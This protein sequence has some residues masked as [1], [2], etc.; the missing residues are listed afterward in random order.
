M[1]NKDYI[2]QEL[3][4]ISNSIDKTIINY[5]EVFINK[6][7]GQIIPNECVIPIRSNGKILGYSIISK[8]YF[9]K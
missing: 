1:T 6:E 8:D 5:S 4:K 2:E 3:D 7:T 9:I